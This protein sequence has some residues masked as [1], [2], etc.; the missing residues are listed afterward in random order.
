MIPIDL[1][2]VWLSYNRYKDIYSMLKIKILASKYRYEMQIIELVG[3]CLSLVHI[4]V[5]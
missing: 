3:R 1:I 2:F 4:F 5:I